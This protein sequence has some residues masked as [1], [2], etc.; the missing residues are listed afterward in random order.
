MF[1]R[2]KTR[3]K[4]GKEHR[5]WSVVENRRVADGRVVQV[6]YPDAGQSGSSPSYLHREGRPRACMYAWGE[7]CRSKTARRP[8]AAEAGRCATLDYA[9]VMAEA[10]QSTAMPSS[11]ETK[12]AASTA[13]FA[14]AKSPAAGNACPAM[15]RDM[16]KPMPASAPAPPSC[17][18]E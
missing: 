15:K 9:F 11:D 14:A 1:L 6:S 10:P 13:I 4:D 12:E 2:S 17:P 18:Q 16:V 8:T 3:K 5:Y 7:R